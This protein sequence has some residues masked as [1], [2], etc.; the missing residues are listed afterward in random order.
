MELAVYIPEQEPQ[1]GAGQHRAAGDKNRGE[2]QTCSRHKE[3]GDVFVTVWDHHEAV[4]LVGDHH[5]LG[6]V[7][8][9]VAGHKGILHPDMTHRDT[10]AHRDSREHHRR[11]ACSADTRLDCLGNLVDVHV[12]GDDFVVGTDHPDQGAGNLFFG[13][14]QGVQKAA[15][16]R[17]L[18][19]GLDGF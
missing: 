16:R 6:G 11:A 1:E 2:I 19:A 5:G 9:Q 12:T 10:V 15:V 18:H 17:A 4:K 14:A 8:D 7:G 3:A 13:K